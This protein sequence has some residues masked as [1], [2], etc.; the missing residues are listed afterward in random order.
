MITD[1]SLDLYRYETKYPNDPNTFRV[2]L[3]LLLLISMPFT[4][5]P[6]LT[7]AIF[8]AFVTDWLDGYL[9][10]NGIAYAIWRIFDPVADK[11][12]VA[13]A[14]VLIVEYQHSFWVTLLGDR[15]D[16]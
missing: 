4:W 15:H 9:L 6:L 13:A 2:V 14:L 5:A 1:Y 12:M 10:K 8:V 11:I 3:I 16:F 7:T